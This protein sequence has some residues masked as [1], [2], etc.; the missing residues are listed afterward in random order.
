[1]VHQSRH[2]KASRGPDPLQDLQPR[3]VPDLRRTTTRSRSAGSKDIP[4]DYD[5]RDG[6]A[7]SPSSTT[8]NPDQFEIVGSSYRR[9]ASQCREIRRKKE[10]YTSGR[11]L[12]STSTTGDG[13]I[14]NASLTRIVI[15]NKRHDMKIEP[16][17]MKV[18]DLTEGYEDNEEAGRCRL[19]AASWT[20]A[21]HISA[22]SSTRTSSVMR[23]STRS[24]E[25]FP[26]N[27]MYWAR[28][29][30]T[31]T[32]RSST[33]SSAPSRSVSTSKATSHSRA[34]TSTTFRE[35]EQE[36]HPRLRADGLRVQRD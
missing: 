19:L 16:K 33:G 11:D 12:A 7:R 25:D 28:A 34:A 5:G 20:F 9:R 17:D 3:R 22:S 13:T 14:P 24:R 36:Q 8:H 29:E 35:D 31:A 15:R 27:V 2:R 6:C 23:S 30:M 1:M 26:L 10:A 21:R 18:R 4:V 32:T